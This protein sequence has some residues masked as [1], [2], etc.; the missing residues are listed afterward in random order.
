MNKTQILNMHISHFV[1][2]PDSLIDILKYNDEN[3][4]EIDFVI[5]TVHINFSDITTID[6]K[7]SRMKEDKLYKNVFLRNLIPRGLCYIFIN[8]VYVH[9]LFGH[10]KFGYFGDY[11]DGIDMTNLQNYTKIYRRK[12][13]GECG[14]ITSFMHDDEQFIVFGSK[15]VHLV[16]NNINDL[17]L[18][19]YDEQ[20]YLYAKKFAKN[21]LEN[22]FNLIPNILSFCNETKNT[23]CFEACFLDSQHLVSYNNDSFFFFAITNENFGVMDPIKTDLIFDELGLLKINETLIGY[24]HD[25]QILI[26]KKIESDCNSEGA[27][28][29][30]MDNQNVIYIYKHKN[31][32]YIFRRAAREQMKK[33]I[34]FRILLS[35]LNNLHIQHPNSEQ[36][37]NKML[38]FYAYYKTLS[39]PEQNDFFHKWITHENIFNS[40]DSDKKHQLYEYCINNIRKNDV[41]TVIMFIGFPGSGKSFLARSLCKLLEN[42]YK[43]IVFLEQDMFAHCGK[44]A[45]KQYDKAIDTAIHDNDLELLILAKSNHNKLVRNKTYD[46]LNK[47]KKEIE[48][49]YISIGVRQN[50]DDNSSSDNHNDDNN[51][52][53]NDLKF[54][55]DVCVQ[56]ILNRKYS[57]QKIIGTSKNKISSVLNNIFV[58]QYEPLDQNEIA[59]IIINLPITFDKS[60]AIKFILNNICNQ[61]EIENL[62]IEQAIDFVK[63]DDEKITKETIKK[64]LVSYD[65]IHISNDDINNI[66]LSYNL[67]NVIYTNNLQIKNEFH[68]TL[69]YYGKKLIT[70]V[71]EFIENET[72]TIE[73]IGYACDNKAIALYVNIPE[74]IKRING[75]KFNHITLALSN[76]TPAKYSSEL[77][78]KA[79]LTNKIV[80]LDK[81]HIVSGETFRE[82][83]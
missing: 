60:D 33:N 29:H 66:I 76:N 73:I 34:P 22:Q 26:E 4:N 30:V 10:K 20:R 50:N 68:I 58:K 51:D 42:K 24:T 27:V 16:I 37:K 71:C 32:D 49:I 70:H 18:E 61:D 63:R 45:S 6:I 81:P 7:L 19:L 59:N 52:A 28:V 31:F 67:N 40:F 65:G 1:D 82:Y 2:V 43:K 3:T 36:L 77:L 56:R 72:V 80:I 39:Q 75:N 35:R 62:N 15:N 57:H 13:N 79:F 5:R 8:N 11:S 55:T 48:K 9:L 83:L 69:E 74:K 41:L 21:F 23:L 44:N 38:Q 17:S 78:E 47:S 53:N 12:E 54:I 25:E 14:H 46:I 64:L